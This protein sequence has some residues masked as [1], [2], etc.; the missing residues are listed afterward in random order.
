MLR[1]VALPNAIQSI[2][3]FV[4]DC[5]SAGCFPKIPGV[6]SATICYNLSV[7]RHFFLRI[8]PAGIIS[9]AGFGL[10]RWQTCGRF[11][12]GKI[13]YD[14]CCR[15]PCMYTQLLDSFFLMLISN[16]LAR[17]KGSLAEAGRSASLRYID[18]IVCHRV[19]SVL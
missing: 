8:W 2:C 13:S 9:C 4:E 14:G 5:S 15:F 11:C 19:G 10:G 16:S 1:G 7:V 17:A 6:H 3:G 12:S 18:C